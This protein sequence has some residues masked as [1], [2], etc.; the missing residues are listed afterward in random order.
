ML[1]RDQYRRIRSCPY[2]WPGRVRACPEP[3]AK[4]CRDHSSS[5][6]WADLD[7][8]G[9]QPQIRVGALKRALTK[10]LDLLIQAATQCRDTILCHPGTAGCSSRRDPALCC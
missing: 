2:K 5:D 8:L 3:F 10:H 7:V 4:A 9:V 6:V 1:N